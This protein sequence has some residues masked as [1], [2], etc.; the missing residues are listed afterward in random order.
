ME[1]EILIILACVPLYV[2]NSFYIEFTTNSQDDLAECNLLYASS[3]SIDISKY[4]L[5]FYPEISLLKNSIIKVLPMKVF[6]FRLQYQ[7]ADKLLPA[8]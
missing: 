8:L 4:L 6:S 7:S 3:D 5:F 2:L 1:F